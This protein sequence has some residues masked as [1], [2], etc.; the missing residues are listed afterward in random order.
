MLNAAALSAIEQEVRQCFIYEDAPEHLEILEQQ[1]LHLE[2][3]GDYPDTNTAHWRSLLRSIHTLKGS[4]ALSQLHN[5]SQLAHRLEDV[6]LALGDR[7]LPDPRLTVELL[8]LGVDQIRQ[9]LAQVAH[10]DQD[11]PPPEILENIDLLLAQSFLSQGAEA[12]DMVAADG[13]NGA[14][15]SLAH[16]IQVVLDTDFKTCVQ[17][18]LEQLQ[19]EPPAPVGKVLSLLAQDCQ[20]LGEILKLDWLTQAV[21][22]LRAVEKSTGLSAEAHR[23]A[24]IDAVRSLEQQR[25]TTL[26]KSD[27]GGSNGSH[28]LPDEPT[29]V[30]GGISEG[31]ANSLEDLLM[32][33]LPP[34]PLGLGIPGVPSSITPEITDAATPLGFSLSPHPLPLDQ[35]SIAAAAMPEAGFGSP[36]TH[37]PQGDPD[38]DSAEGIDPGQGAV[39]LFPS[40]FSSLELDPV[41]TSL[42]SINPEPAPSQPETPLPRAIAPPPPPRPDE[43]SRDLTATEFG[44]TDLTASDLPASDLPVSDFGITDLT[45]SDLPATD[46]SLADLIGSDLTASDLTASDLTASDLPAT[47]FSL[48]DLIGSDL[49]ASDLPVSDLPVSD[50]GLA[51]LIGSDLPASDLPASDFGLADLIG[52]DIPASDIPASNFSLIDL[53]ASDI[54][55]RDFSFADLIGSDIPASD[56]PASDFS[57]ADLI[58]SDIADPE[59]TAFDRTGTN[60]T[61]AEVSLADLIGPDV[62][63]THVTNTNVTNTNVTNT[64]VTNTNVTNTNATLADFVG[65]DITNPET[66]EVTNADSGFTDLITLKPEIS[67]PTALKTTATVETSD[68]KPPTPVPASLPEATMRLSISRL[69]ALADGVGD[70]LIH[71]EQ[72]NLDHQRLRRTSQELKR[73]TRQFYR[74]RERIQNCY[75]GMLLPTRQGYAASNQG[76]FDTLELDQFTDLHSLLQDLQEF[77]SRID[78]YADDISLINQSA[79]ESQSSVR[80]ELDKVR[81][82]LTEARM[83]RFETLADRFRRPLWDLNHR[84]HK[85]VQFQINGGDTEVDR[86]ILDSLYDPLLHLIRNAFD[87]GQE[88]PTDRQ[89]QGKPAQG[90]ITLAAQQAG[91]SIII[92]VTDDG[93]G[94]DVD[95]VQAKAQRLGLLPA[96]SNSLS[97]ILQCLFSPGFSTAA[98]VGELSGRGVGMDVV[99]TQ[100]EHLRGSVDIQTR[101]GQ[102]TCFSLRV[103]STLNILPLLLCQQN[104]PWGPPAVVAIPSSQVLEIVELDSSTLGADTLM[105]HDRPLPLLQLSQLLPA[106]QHPWQ[107]QALTPDLA[108]QGWTTQVAKFSGAIAAILQ[109][110]HPVAL[111]VDTLLEEREMVLKALESW[112]PIPPY[113]AGCTLLPQGQVVPV[114]SPEA[115]A[116][117]GGQPSAMPPA[118]SPAAPPPLAAVKTVLVVDDSVAARRWLSHALTQVGHQVVQ[119][120]DGQEAWE[121][122]QEGLDCQ[123]LISDVEMPRLDGFQLLQRVREDQRFHQLPVAMLTSRQS[124][125]H[126]AQAESLGATAYFTKPLGIQEL[127]LSIEK[128]FEGTV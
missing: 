78:E 59:A 76:G 96:G 22:L 89:N 26:E 52:S 86:A 39:H 10:T 15:P 13:F 47:D 107:L 95:Q 21:P 44:I 72:V 123:L 11:C 40:D 57:L 5:L 112:L 103:P 24:A 65:S 43:T 74:L 35:S 109:A 71:S 17:R 16:L 87:H 28:G 38:L 128:L 117:P 46:F 33:P 119:C 66:A 97:Q 73:Q 20:T 120:R 98:Q 37:P 105:W 32:A 30:R 121:R 56:V 61:G 111:Q 48:A 49:T 27:R 106:P 92:S 113:V 41:P 126:I 125:R 127:V 34:P 53:P 118:D 58:G 84:Y 67:S 93:Q 2:G 55:A 82:G 36:L 14:D 80:Q 4:A 60:V 12:A 64:N 100:I 1:L 31:V 69:N 104:R 9:Q 94:I 25:Q 116:S 88:L 70:L 51:D 122:L 18:S 99:K 83:V 3:T 62:T 7:H 19:R 102:G 108:P 42:G 68:P 63:N 50:F 90:T 45:A 54:P 75:D 101:R 114:L 77:L 23:S 6:L 115:L 79:Q 8:L 85:Q 91:T 81:Q 110:P 124:D 29:E